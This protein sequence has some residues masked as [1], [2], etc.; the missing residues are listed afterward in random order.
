MTATL[1]SLFQQQGQPGAPPAPGTTPP[2]PTAPPAAPTSAGGMQD[3]ANLAQQQLQQLMGSPVEKEREQYTQQA[4]K[5]AGQAAQTPLPQLGP[6]IQKGGGFLHNL[7][8]ALQMISMATPA[9]RNVFGPS[10]P[11]YGPG[12]AQYRATQAGLMK[13]QQTAEKGAEEAGKGVQA[14]AGVTGRTIYGGAQVQ[15]GQIQAD[16]MGKRIVQQHQDNLA[17]IAAMTDMNAK[18]VAMQKEVADIRSDAEVE[19]ARIGGTTREDVAGILANSA[20]TIKNLGFAEDPSIWGDIKR[21]LLGITAVEAP[22]GQSPVEGNA[23]APKRGTAPPAKG[24]VV[25]RGTTVYDPQ[26]QPHSSDGTHPLP[27]GW[28]LKKPGA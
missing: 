18:R 16:V 4:Q 26:G 10:G 5:F 27:K 14:L 22:G 23:P 7:G 13:E 2:T 15:K 12:V 28:S 25:P 8:Q 1:A 11:V 19:A 6:R 17:R 9:G 20:Q 24:N 21:N 3:Y